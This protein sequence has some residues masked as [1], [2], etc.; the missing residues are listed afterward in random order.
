MKDVV[1]TRV[2]DV[3]GAAPPSAEDGPDVR[4]GHHAAERLM[5][6]EKLSGLTGIAT[7]WE[8]EKELAPEKSG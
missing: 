7:V 5:P 8:L 1:K 2:Y 3:A 4:K 6:L